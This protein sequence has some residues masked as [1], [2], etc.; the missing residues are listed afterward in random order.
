MTKIKVIGVGSPYGADSIAW[1]VIDNLKQ[2]HALQNL[3]AD[4]LTFINCDR[5]GAALLDYLQGE[6]YV[7]VVDALAGG[8]PGSYRDFDKQQILRLLSSPEAQP[9]RAISSH[10]FGVTDAFRLAKQLN[11]LPKTLRLI[12]IEIGDPGQFFTFQPS[13][14][15][16]INKCIVSHIHDYCKI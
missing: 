9:G 16:E 6:D 1:Q 7:I 15:Q 11:V 10:Y 2:N 13:D 5:P 3:Y 4:E 8:L 14:M 12:A